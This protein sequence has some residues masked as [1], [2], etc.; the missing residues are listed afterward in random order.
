[1]AAPPVPVEAP[2][3]EPREHGPADLEHLTRLWTQVLELLERE[4]P[5]TRGFLDGSRPMRVEDGALDVAVTSAM[6]ASMLGRIEHRER[7]RGA[8]RTVSG[9]DLTVDFVP[10]EAVPETAPERPAEPR[11]HE[12]LLEELKTMFGAVEEDGDRT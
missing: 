5:P 9:H 12:S 3:P 2:A 4:A 1:M 8:V 6:R 7:V 11:D 10:G